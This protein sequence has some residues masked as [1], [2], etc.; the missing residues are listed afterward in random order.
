M[1]WG[2]NIRFPRGHK[3]RYCFIAAAGRCLSIRFALRY[4]RYKPLGTDGAPAVPDSKVWAEELV[5]IYKRNPVRFDCD[6]RG[7]SVK[8]RGTVDNI[9]ASGQVVL[10]RNTKRKKP[11]VICEFET[12]CMAADL[13]PKQ[14]ITVSGNLDSI[15]EVN[16]GPDR[17]YELRMV[18]CR[19]E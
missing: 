14:Q 7:S 5:R 19:R 9:R 3:Q 17:F 6:S 13:D 11:R 4:K 12:R 10:E 1:N 8:T 18:N 2:W 15:R 16:P